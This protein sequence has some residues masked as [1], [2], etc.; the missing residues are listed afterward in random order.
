MKNVLFLLF[1]MLLLLMSCNNKEKLEKEIAKIEVDVTLE[2]FDKAFA[3]ATPKNLADLKA[4]YPYLF[5]QQFSDSV[6]MEK[7][8]D[9]LQQELFSE[10]ARTFPNLDGEKSELK[11]LFQHI[12]YYFP[13]VET[14]KI[15][16]LTSEVDYR[17]KVI[18]ADSLV[19][20]SLDTYLGE[21]HKFYKGIPEYLRKNLKREQLIVDVASAFAEK[22]ISYPKDR[23]FLA[24]MVYF[25]KKLYL[26]DLLIPFKTDAQKIG[27]SD[28]EF[29]WAIANESEMWR[30]FVE[31]QLLFSTESSLRERFINPAPFS[32]FYLELDK[33]SPGK[34][35]QY[36]G[37]QI[38]RAYM[39]NNDVAVEKMLQTSA[40]DIFTNSKFK[41]KK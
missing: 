27:Y 41:P 23:S 4:K 31:K 16:T 18:Y 3:N 11:S 30:Y 28:D 5:P 38:V 25:G 29:S 12:N 21:N 34:L 15:I 14:P 32:K 35:G 40:E 13:K 6:W 20:I 7:M 17:N 22:Q 37:W 9:T 33:E 24:A 19:L 39:K 10:V 36:I 1:F 26:K 8:S 2:R